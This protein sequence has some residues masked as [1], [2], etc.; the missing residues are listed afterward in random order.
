MLTICNEVL[1]R[2]RQPINIVVTALNAEIL[3]QVND[4]HVLRNAMLLEECLTLA[5][6]EA[7]EHHIHL[8]KRHL[9]SKLQVRI[10]DETFM[11]V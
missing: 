8:V 10:T 4:L 6:A 9:V 5:V 11:H 7:E 2:L 3:C 1:V